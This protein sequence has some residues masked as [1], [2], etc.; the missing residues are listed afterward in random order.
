MDP[1]LG[2]GRCWGTPGARWADTTIPSQVSSPPDIPTHGLQEQCGHGL[3]LPTIAGR[4]AGRQP[5][6]K[7]GGRAL[8]SV[9]QCGAVQ[10]R[11]SCT[12]G[13]PTRTRTGAEAERAASS[14]ATP[15]R[16]TLALLPWPWQEE[17][18]QPPASTQLG[19]TSA[20]TPAPRRRVPPGLQRYHRGRWSVRDLACKPANKKAPAG[21]ENTMLPWG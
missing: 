9:S 20:G 21:Q 15:S 16:A 5:P 12:T 1:P 10:L 11:A 4:A 19:V 17:R 8:G 6:G 3:T 13:H 18:S 14:S 7:M 2:T